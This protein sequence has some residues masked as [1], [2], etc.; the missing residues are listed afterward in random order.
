MRLTLARW[1]GLGLTLLT[2][3]ASAC[4]PPGQ[5]AAG[6]DGTVEV[7]VARPAA[8]AW[9]AAGPGRPGAAL[10]GLP[11][12]LGAGPGDSVVA[13]TA[14][15]AGGGRVSVEVVRPRGAAGAPPAGQPLARLETSGL[16]RLAT[17]GRRSAAVLYQQRTD[18]RAPAGTAPGPEGGR[19]RLLWIDLVRRDSRPAPG[20][21][22]PGE[23]LRALA[24]EPAGDRDGE[25]TPAAFAFVGLEGTSGGSENGPG[26][27][28]MVAL[29][30][31]AVV[32]S[33]TLGGTPVDLRLAAGGAGAPAGLFVLEQS[34]GAGGLVPT[35]EQGR[36]LV[37]DPLTLDVLSEHPLN[38]PA[39]RL[40]PAPD[41]RSVLLVHQDTVRRLDLTSGKELLMVRLPGRVVA[42]ELLGDRLY[43]GSPEA[44]AL[45]VVDPRT[46]LRQPDRPL[47]GPP[48]SLAPAWR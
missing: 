35:A 33:R 43:L 44:H 45:F 41:G 34:G 12:Q 20:P 42:A 40:L 4:A 27:V 6:R 7:G 21:C 23:H 15:P 8:V 2:L 3:P 36:V 22:R 32:G 29:P 14:D 46:G 17:D 1:L 39:A 9:L 11:E 28:V 25:R 18:G 5:G 37:L 26:R 31:G 48:I 47:P 38:A 19:C 10:A 13:L 24:L 16:A 30:A